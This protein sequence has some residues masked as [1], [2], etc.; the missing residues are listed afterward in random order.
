MEAYAAKLLE[1]GGTKQTYNK[2]SRN[3]MQVAFQRQSKVGEK[4]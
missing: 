3:T 2:G 4:A 1:G